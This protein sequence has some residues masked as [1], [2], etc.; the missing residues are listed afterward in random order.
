LAEI[1][2]IS[3]DRGAQVIDRLK[4]HLSKMGGLASSL[5]NTPLR[6]KEGTPNGSGYNLY[7]VRN[8]STPAVAQ[9]TSGQAMFMPRRFIKMMPPHA[10]VPTMHKTATQRRRPANHSIP[11]NPTGMKRQ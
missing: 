4:V 1:P 3:D 10:I 8:I 6:S 9:K 7:T 5:L 11:S 2:E